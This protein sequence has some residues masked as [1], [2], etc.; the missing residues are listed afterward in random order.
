MEFKGFFLSLW[1]ALGLERIASDDW[2]RVN[3]LVKIR[4]NGNVI[5]KRGD[6]KMTIHAYVFVVL[7]HNPNTR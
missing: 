5:T 6:K 2:N 1:G 3:T 4:R 7:F